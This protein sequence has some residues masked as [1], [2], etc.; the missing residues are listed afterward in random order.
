M[1]FRLQENAFA[2]QNID[3]RHF[4]PCI[5]SRQNCLPSTYHYPPGL[6]QIHMA[7]IKLKHSEV[8]Y[9]YQV[10]TEQTFMCKVMFLYELWLL[11]LLF[12]FF[13]YLLYQPPSHHV[14]TIFHLFE[15]C[16]WIIQ[17]KQPFWR[18]TQFVVKFDIKQKFS[19]NV[20]VSTYSGTFF[21]K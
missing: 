21:P 3:S 8:V 17:E 18:K 2:S 5:H 4:H 6:I 11:K 13:F 20:T 1:V 19:L 16:E 7:A 14:D 12:F 15:L 9:T 10:S